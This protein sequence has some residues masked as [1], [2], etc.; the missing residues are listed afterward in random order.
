MMARTDRH[1]RRFMRCITRRTLLYTEMVTTHAIQFGSAERLLAFDP[2]EHPVA[3]QLGGDDPAALA[4][5]ARIAEDLGYD[6][7]NLNVGCPSSRVSSGHFGVCLMKDPPLVAD[8]IAT[9]RAAVAIPVTIKHRVGVDDQD[10]YELL[11]AFIRT[12]ASAGCERFTIH[13]RK[14]W[15]KGLS[16]KE[17]RNIPPLRYDDVYRIKRALPDLFV[18]LNG[19]VRSLDAADGHLE[20]VDAVM[21][22]R[23]AYD[24]PWLFAGADQRYFGASRDVSREEVVDEMERYLADRLAKGDRLLQ[25]VRH[26]MQFFSHEPGTRAWKRAL[27]DGASDGAG[28][29]VLRRALEAAGRIASQQNEGLPINRENL[30]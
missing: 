25:V 1:Y 19:G 23:A 12:V 18:E 28:A 2:V 4:A 7:V 24:N 20:Q 27:T 22:G 9:M 14:A 29:T 11:E 13:A 16:P 30:A 26:M 10:S 3:L 17:N 21:I 6:E 5:C 8:A 15:L